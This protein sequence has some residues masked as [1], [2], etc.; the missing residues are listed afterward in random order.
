M[1]LNADDLK[2]CKTEELEVAKEEGKSEEKPAEEKTAASFK[3]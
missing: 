3:I 2:T 1:N